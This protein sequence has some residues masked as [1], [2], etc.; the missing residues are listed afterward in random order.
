MG[1]VEEGLTAYSVLTSMNSCE[2]VWSRQP[3]G[4]PGCRSKWDCILGDSSFSIWLCS[5]FDFL[6]YSSV[7]HWRSSWFFIIV[8]PIPIVSLCPERLSLSWENRSWVFSSAQVRPLLPMGLY[9]VTWKAERGRV[10]LLTQLCQLITLGLLLLSAFVDF[11]QG[12]FPWLPV[13]GPGQTS[14]IWSLT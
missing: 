9:S 1:V 5:G 6:F 12:A 2:G 3:R 11:E 13:E 4:L 14:Y 10:G 8:A 7:W